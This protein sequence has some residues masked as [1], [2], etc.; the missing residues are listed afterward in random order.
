M[1]MQV[2][3]T[4]AVRAWQTPKT[5]GSRMLTVILPS[6]RHDKDAHTDKIEVKNMEDLN[7]HVN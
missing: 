1:L 2:G 3:R 6:A 7:K 4:C 5:V